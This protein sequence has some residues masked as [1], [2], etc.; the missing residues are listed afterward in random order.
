MGDTREGAAIGG[1]LGATAGAII[2]HQEG[3]QGE[4][5]LIGAGV[6]AL[7]GA[8]VG[9]AIDERKD[10]QPPQTVASPAFPAQTGRHALR[11]TRAAS[12]EAYEEMA[13]AP[14]P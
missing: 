1:I 14:E 10:A 6:G 3:N 2:G 12:G 8:L 9:D 5:A 13:T 11:L 7:A 4:G